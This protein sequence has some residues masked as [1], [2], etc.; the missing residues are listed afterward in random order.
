[1]CLYSEPLASIQSNMSLFRNICPSSETTHVFVQR[2]LS[3]QSH[4]S[5]SICLYW[6]PHESDR[7]PP[8]SVPCDNNSF[9][10]A[11]VFQIVFSPWGLPTKTL[12][13]VSR[14]MQ[15]VTFRSRDLATLAATQRNALLRCQRTRNSGRLRPGL[16]SLRRKSNKI[17]N[18]I[19]RGG[20]IREL[21]LWRKE[22]VWNMQIDPSLRTN[23]NKT[24]ER[25]IRHGSPAQ[26]AQPQEK[27][28]VN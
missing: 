20:G 15:R 9:I 22:I 24:D 2:H 10:R 19:L 1:M 14:S 8:I 23:M 27:I 12:A 25:N 6:E 17:L 5:R 3:I 11:H 16:V 4:M 13:C 26:W 7:R 18:I 21:R 28:K